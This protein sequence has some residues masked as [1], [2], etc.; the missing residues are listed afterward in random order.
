M[1]LGDGIRRN[2]A[3]VT[4]E[5][6]D[7]LRDAIIALHKNYHYPGE[8]DK[9]PPGGVSYWFKQDEIHDGGHVHVCP[10]F[11]PWHRELINRFENL[12]RQVDPALSLHY[13]DWTTDPGWMFTNDFMGNAHGDAGEP[14][15]AN[16]SPYRKDGFYNPDANP[17]RDSSEN[18]FDPPLHIIRNVRAGAPFTPADD[19]R[20]LAAS[21]FAA[22]D[23]IMER[24]SDGG[25]N[26]D[27]GLHGIAHGW[28]G[29]TLDFPHTSFRDPFVFLLHSNVDRLF[30]TWQLQRGHSKRLDPA[31]IYDY[32]PNDWKDPTDPTCTRPKDPEKGDG[33]LTISLFPW[34]G[35]SSPMEPWAG[36][37]AQTPATGI[38]KNIKAVRPW[39]PPENQQVYK[40]SRDHSVVLPLRYDTN[41]PLPSGSLRQF[42]RAHGI[43]PSRGI[44]TPMRNAS[45]TCVRAFMGS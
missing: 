32:G 2:I 38:V 37:D 1:A 4:K 16:V 40:D 3:T 23:N 42:L 30:A 8:P 35:F 31:H 39:A 18:P 45:F 43:N 36:V 21:T 28:I 13:W 12:L 22:F 20:L 14:W 33:D 41:P 29:G 7:R 34:W 24:S 26:L 27:D 10:A 25:C 9:L 11:L 44:R 17:N 19:Q 15:Q 5:E 6:R